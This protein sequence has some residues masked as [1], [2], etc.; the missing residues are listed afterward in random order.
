M[1]AHYTYYN[2]SLMPLYKYNLN[3]ISLY[4]LYLLRE[5]IINNNNYIIIKINMRVI[6]IIDQVINKKLM[7]VNNLI[8]K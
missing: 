6:N 1:K 8:S 7:N 3:N 2:N 5:K 4:E